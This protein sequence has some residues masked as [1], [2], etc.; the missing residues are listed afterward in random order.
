MLRRVT[1]NP[2]YSSP[3][4]TRYATRD[5]VANFDDRRRYVL[6]RRLWIALA[7]AQAEL[8]LPIAPEQIAAMREHE[9]E[10]DLGRVAELESKLRHDVMA[11][12][13]HFGELV[14]PGAEK[15]I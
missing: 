8:G 15:V 14:G 10:L 13:R 2:E 4:A 12:V 9:G 1:A 7:E 5:M 11:H 6:W 3:L